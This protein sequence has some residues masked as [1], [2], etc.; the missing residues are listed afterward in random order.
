MISNCRAKYHSL[1]DWSLHPRAFAPKRQVHN[2]SQ[3]HAFQKV[4][5]KTPNLLVVRYRPMRPSDDFFK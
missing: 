5:R 1:D 4:A 2:A 3:V